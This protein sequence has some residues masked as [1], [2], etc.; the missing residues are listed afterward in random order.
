[1]KNNLIKSV[2]MMSLFISVNTV[3]QFHFLYPNDTYKKTG[4]MAF[5]NGFGEFSNERITGGANGLIKLRIHNIILANA[6]V[7]AWSGATS[8]LNTTE[9][10]LNFDYSAALLLGK[11]DAF[12]GGFFAGYNDG[13]RNK[14]ARGV[15]MKDAETGL[16]YNGMRKEDPSSEDLTLTFNAK[17]PYYKVGFV[18]Y[19]SLPED[20]KKSEFYF[21]YCWTNLP[22]A[23]SYY[24]PIT[25]YRANVPAGYNIEG[26]AHTR[27][28]FGLCFNY[29]FL[30]AFNYGVD[31]GFRPAH[32]V[33]SQLEG[34]PFKKGAFLTLTLGF[35]VF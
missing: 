28:G 17:I 5:A 33:Q 15:F 14:K 18:M 30:N 34:K 27:K 7:S 31:V 32:Y 25:Y 35:R 13:A 6:S 23:S 2:L 12:K 29:Y 24:M 19:S 22:Q 8:D 10:I 11:N 21:Y 9:S 4:V 16:L 26:L 3:G 1:M 20:G